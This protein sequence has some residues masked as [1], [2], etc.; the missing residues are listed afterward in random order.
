MA[1]RA[2]H[3]DPVASCSSR[4]RCESPA[5]KRAPSRPF[6]IR[7]EVPLNRRYRHPENEAISEAT[8]N[9]KNTELEPQFGQ[10]NY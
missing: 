6:A 10:V 2:D 9:I 5:L 7:L 3:A 4:M 8:A 1:Q